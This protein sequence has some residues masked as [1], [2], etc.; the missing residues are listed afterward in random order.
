MVDKLCT[1][2]VVTVEDA[3]NA[4]PLPSHSSLSGR[5][6]DWKISRGRFSDGAVQGLWEHNV[7][8]SQP[9]KAS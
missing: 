1:G 5:E 7:G 6:A 4:W 2:I 8:A 9:G 3:R